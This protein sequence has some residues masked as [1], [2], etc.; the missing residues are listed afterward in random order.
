MYLNYYITK[1]SDGIDHVKMMTEPV[2]QGE[3][4]YP[5]QIIVEELMHTDNI[6][7]YF[8]YKLCDYNAD[9]I[10]SIYGYLLN[11][12]DSFLLNPSLLLREVALEAT[13]SLE[14][15]VNAFNKTEKEYP[16][17]CT[18][19]DSFRLNV[20]N[21]PDKIAVY[22]GNNTWTYKELDEISNGI[23]KM[24]QDRGMT[25]GTRMC[26][27]SDHTKEVLA[28]ILGIMKAGGT[29]IPVDKKYPVERIN[30]ILSDTQAEF[31]YTDEKRTDIDYHNKWLTADDVQDVNRLRD[32]NDVP[33]SID[34]AY[35]IYTSGSTGKPKGVMIGH[36][37]LMNYAYWATDVYMS[38]SDDIFA[39]YSS[40]A[41]DLTVTSIFAPLV[42]GKSIDVYRSNEED[43]VLHQILDRN[44]AT[45]VKLTPSHLEV[46][47]DRDNTSSCVRRFVVGGENLTSHL[48]QSVYASFEGV[49]I[50]NEYGPTEATV[51]CMIH[52]FDPQVDVEGSVPIG[53]PGANAHIYILDQ[54]GNLLPPGCRGEIYI[55]GDGLAYGY[56]NR[57]I[58]SKER[59]V[60]NSDSPLPCKRLYK[61]GDIGKWLNTGFIEYSGRVDSQVK[62][63]G[64]R[65]EL[66]EITTAM[67]RLEGINKAVAKDRIDKRGHKVLCGYIVA[68]AP[69]EALDVKGQLATV[70]P[71][72]ML[73]TFIIEV[74]EIPLTVNGKINF[75]KLPAVPNVLS[76]ASVLVGDIEHL[77]AQILQDVLKVDGINLDDNFFY[78]GGDSIKAIQITSRLK[79]AGYQLKVKDL[80]GNGSLRSLVGNITE[81]RN[82][83]IIEQG[84]SYGEIAKTPIVEWFNR[85][86]FEN[87]NHYNQSVLLEVPG[88]YSKEII[89]ESIKKLI[90]H[91]DILRA[92]YN[93]KTGQLRY[94]ED[95]IDNEVMIDLFEADGFSDQE[96]KDLVLRASKI[97][98]GNLEISNKAMIGGCIFKV[99]PDVSY[100]LL[101]CHHLIVDGISWRIMIDDLGRILEK[102]PL[103]QKT[104][105]Y[106]YWAETL[107]S[108]KDHVADE[109]DYWHRV[110]SI[111]N[112]I[113]PDYKHGL[114]LV[115]TTETLTKQIP[116]SR[117]NELTE[118]MNETFKMDLNESLIGALGLVMK[119]QSAKD[120]IVIDMERHGRQ[121]VIEDLDISRTV[122][123][124]T[125]IYPLQL[126]A[127]GIDLEDQVKN[128]KESMRAVPEDGFNYGFYASGPLRN[129]LKAKRRVRFNYLGELV[130]DESNLI[131]LVDMPTGN[132]VADA[133]HMTALLDFN[134]LLK[135]DHLEI[136]MTYSQDQFNKARAEAILVAYESQ[137]YQ[138]IE[139]CKSADDVVF[140]PSDFD[141]LDIS[142]EDLDILLG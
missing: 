138:L 120:H 141:A 41:F 51:G 44:R 24:L 29:Y 127:E 10:K 20:S 60:Y 22:E 26:L 6:Q 82:K 34:L 125:S 105:A 109:S 135:G 46:I 98:K 129:Q 106:Q 137:L 86:E 71:D 131:K 52:R 134:L 100:L 58:L 39:F 4:N 55:G 111:D 63:R 121:Q 91:H 8:D 14:S 35:I 84:Y 57:D 67:M 77:F 78:L 104:H 68:E 32:F 117:V 13:E 53:V 64:H 50:I 28:V 1:Y 33:T 42:G 113:E 114:G 5:L 70:L 140:S 72:Y 36:R 96:K 40:L 31:I 49:E 97:Y 23:A 27:M 132:E 38:D 130:Q 16:I 45:V 128:L 2:Y 90:N 21:M 17:N 110:E 136:R 66:D 3:Q 61:T 69:L 75:D 89:E 7:L 112:P 126:N 102:R 107:Q 47:K 11:M 88:Q 56:L 124:F 62:I 85:Q 92:T 9:T 139:H 93:K 37:S 48:C 65:I 108:Y 30:F 123:W 18:V 133:N 116:K 43:F 87:P 54:D 59:F 122:G 15:R 95:R 103:P 101:T 74:D 12:I 115:A 119:H 19:L 25:R 118:L 142:Q 80:M 79:E 83:M 99:S 81:L 76:E 73:P 94:N